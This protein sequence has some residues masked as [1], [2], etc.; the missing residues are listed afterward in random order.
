[1]TVMNMVQAINA[2]L[3]S[4]MLQDDRVICLGEDVGRNGGV[5]RVTDGLMDIFG[6]ERV[7][8][9]PL[10]ESA[11]IGAAVG[12]AARGLRPVAEIQFLGFIYEAMDQMA[13]QAAR[14]RFKSGGKFSAPMVVRAPYGGGVRTPELHSDSLEA[15]FLHTPGLKVVM[16]STPYDAKGL[17]TS[18]IRDEDPVLFLEPMKLYRAFSEDVPEEDYEVEIGKAKVIQDGNDLTIISWGQSIHT[19]QKAVKEWEEQKNLSIEIIDLRTIAPLDLDTI[20]QSAK[21]TGRVMIVH[22]AVKSGGVGA[23]LAALISEKAMFYMFAP[24][25]RIAGF[26]TPYPFPMV[27]DEWLPNVERINKAI[28]EMLSYS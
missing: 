2:A 9:T 19:V 6:A 28:E 12:M 20:I 1:M 21:K 18:A 14:L 10:A 4:E 3:K 24:I 23:E 8:D 26:D 15:L 5:F 11:I 16:P 27:E 17:L 13:S 25:L 7:V 22:E